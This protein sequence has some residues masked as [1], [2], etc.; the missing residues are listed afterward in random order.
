VEGSRPAAPGR[1]I[2]AR[3]RQG[4]ADTGGVAASHALVVLAGLGASGSVVV[5]AILVV[6]LHVL[7][8]GVDPVSEGVSAYAL[9]PWANLYQ[10]QVIGCGVAATLVV[11]GCGSLRLGS[12]LGLGALLV[13][14]VTRFVIVR[15]PTDPPRTSAL[16]ATGRTHAALAAASFL[17][18]AVATPTTGLA[19]AGSAPWDPV[20][21]LLVVIS[22]A[23]PI[24]VAATFA[25]GGWPRLRPQ[26]GLVERIVYAT[27]LS[28]LLIVGVRLAAVPAA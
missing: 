17:S 15:Y 10:A 12:P 24:S 20:T 14:A 22:V 28:W 16:S 13:Y 3:D 1:L 25:A 4:R 27:G 21:S 6:R 11:V 19:L 9:T 23:V 2:P 26:F 8:T 7:Q 5:A 18:L